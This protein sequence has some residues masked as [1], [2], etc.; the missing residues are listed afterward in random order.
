M[1]QFLVDVQET[2]F[3]EAGGLA[4]WEEAEHMPIENVLGLYT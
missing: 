2:P 1:V 3:D 4:L